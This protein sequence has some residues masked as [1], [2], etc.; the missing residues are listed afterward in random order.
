MK[1]F[2]VALLKH[3]KSFNNLLLNLSIKSVSSFSYIKLVI[4]YYSYFRF[5]LE[6][7]KGYRFYNLFKAFFKFLT[8]I[9]ILLGLFILIVFTDFRYEEYKQFIHN[10]IT[11]LTFSEFFFKFKNYFKNVFKYIFNSIDDEKVVVDSHDTDKLPDSYKLPRENIDTKSY[12]AYY[13]AIAF[14][15]IVI[16]FKYPEYTVT[17]IISGITSFISS[18]LFEGSD[19]PSDKSADI[20]TLDKGKAKD[21]SKIN[22]DNLTPSSNPESSTKSA[23]PSSTTST[24]SIFDYFTSFS[25]KTVSSLG[26]DPNDNIWDKSDSSS[27]TSSSSSSTVTQSNLP[28]SSSPST[29]HSQTTSHTRYVDPY[30]SE[31]DHY[32]PEESSSSSS[33]VTQSSMSPTSSTSSPTTP[34]TPGGSK[35]VRVR[36]QS[37]SSKNIWK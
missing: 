37:P 30:D 8:L 35:G 25:N 18:F 19:D 12:K 3:I 16:C 24:K 13:C 20:N 34:T 33:T 27:D 32:F 10:I 6:Y 22:T 23:V 14:V 11:N 21:I 29:S 9:N 36:L 17:P 4:K 5:I 31:V 28:S 1:T 7:F 26:V 15:T 2:I